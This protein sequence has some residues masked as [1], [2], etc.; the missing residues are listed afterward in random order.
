[1]SWETSERSLIEETP[2]GNRA[3]VQLLSAVHGP[4]YAGQAA[5][6]CG[7]GKRNV[8]APA[9]KR[10]MRG[11]S[12]AAGRV[13]PSCELPG[14]GGVAVEHLPAGRAVQLLEPF[15]ALGDGTVAELMQRAL[16]RIAAK[17][18]ARKGQSDEKHRVGGARSALAGA[19][20]EAFA[21]GWMEAGRWVSA[22]R[23]SADHRG[24]RGAG[25]HAPA[26]LNS[27]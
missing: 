16:R 10:G 4:Q 6:P 18:G 26:A 8:R 3:N 9:E 27:G 25:L 11:A 13:L 2:E 20:A 7:H 17:H 1:M 15:D 19:W 12:T 5:A 23:N 22:T 24:A 21:H 14:T